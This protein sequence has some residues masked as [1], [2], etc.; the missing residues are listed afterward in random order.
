[1]QISNEVEYQEAIKELSS[2]INSESPISVERL[3]RM[4]ELA[5]AIED[6]EDK[7]GL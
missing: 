1:M 4:N 6:Y 5:D 7:N 3:M 2:I